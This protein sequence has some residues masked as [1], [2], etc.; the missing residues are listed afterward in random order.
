VRRELVPHAVPRD[1]RDTAPADVADDRRRRRLAVRR[2]DVDRL[3][4]IE[5]RVEPGSP[6][7]ADLRGGQDAFS[8]LD[9][10]ALEPAPDD[11]D[12][13]DEEDESLD[14]PDVVASFLPS[15]VPPFVPSRLASG[16]PVLGFERLSVA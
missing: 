4:G 14:A 15:L 13:G 3:G 10:G 11:D 5:E 2:V 12:V 1:E 16:V 9:A 7:D 6:E 8:P